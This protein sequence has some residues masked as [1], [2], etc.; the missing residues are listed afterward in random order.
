[1]TLPS[2]GQ[3]LAQRVI[4]DTPVCFAGVYDVFS[5]TLAGR[6][7]DG[8]FVS[9]YGFA[10]SF[11]GMP[12]I[13]LI[14]W[15]DMAA[16]VQR[17]RIALPSHHLMTDIDD[18]YGDPDVAAHAAVAM[19]RAGTSGVVLEDQRRP[20]RCG[21]VDG[22]QVMDLADF[23]IKL[24]CVRS[25][26]ADLYLVAR[27]DAL[28]S[29]EQIRRVIAFEEAGAD[30]VLI[31]GV[32]NFAVLREAARQLTVPLMFNQIAGGKSPA[33]SL[34]ELSD[35]GVRLVNY[36]TPCLFAAHAAIEA[37]MR[38]LTEN[39][40]VLPTDGVT[41]PRCNAVLHDNLIR[42]DLPPLPMTSPVA[43]VPIVA[44]GRQ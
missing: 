40:G 19:Q 12:D 21:H 16:F 34:S 38:R 42:R 31:D 22:K 28:G 20:R 24:R 4:A 15:A 6:Y 32:T 10:A 25:T 39:D 1:M 13:G 7:F 37:E 11:Y 27:T 44:R 43:L 9:G 23:L 17:L 18:G 33:C 35:I 36:S 2:Y 29:A 26:V 8:I 41:V 14:A 30:A 3:R 5:A